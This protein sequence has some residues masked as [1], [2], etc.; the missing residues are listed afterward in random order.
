MGLKEFFGFGKKRPPEPPPKTDFTL[1]DL[2]V[3]YMVDYDM[4]TWQVEGE[5]YYDW[6]AGDI[7]REWQLK[8]VDD[9]IYLEMEEDDEVEWAIAR[10]IPFGKLGKGVRDHIAEHEEPPEEIVYEGETYYL[11]EGGGGHFYKDGKGPG[12]PL[13]AWDY[14]DDT[15]EKYLSIEQWGEEDFEASAGE[16]VSEY[17]FTN[18]LPNV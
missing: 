9:T 1:S 6:G 16:P 8:S 13:M 15:G 14:E 7:T 2:K 10:K 5:H 12:H 17:Q 4:Q 18:I 3:G 11:E